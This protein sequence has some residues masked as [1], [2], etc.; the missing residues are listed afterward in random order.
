MYN[1][2]EFIVENVDVD[3][4]K[5]IHYSILSLNDFDVLDKTIDISS[6]YL[7]IDKSEFNIKDVLIDCEMETVISFKFKNRQCDF[8]ERYGSQRDYIV[9]RMLPLV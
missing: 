5:T 1:L 8:Y 9:V 6:K 7:N 3:V 2:C 4:D